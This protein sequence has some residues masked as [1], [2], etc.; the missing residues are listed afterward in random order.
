MV[1]VPHVPRH[2]PP[3]IIQYFEHSSDK[4]VTFHS[5]SHYVFESNKDCKCI[6]NNT[7]CKKAALE[8]KY[9]LGF[10]WGGRIH[11]NLKAPQ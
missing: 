2:F 6:K 9:P 4:L 5:L 11:L 3:A 8:T 7:E 10:T 1:T